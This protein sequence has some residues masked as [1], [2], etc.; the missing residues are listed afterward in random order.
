M[1]L[2][3]VGDIA[4]GDHPKAVGFGFYS[5]YKDGIPG[6][7][8][9]QLYPHGIRADLIFGNLEF[10]LADEE[11][12]GHSIHEVYCRGMKRYVTFLRE[13]GFSVLNMA[14]NHQ[15][16]H[17]KKHFADTIDNLKSGGIRVCGTPD[18]FSAENILKVAGQSVAFLGWSE[19]PRQDF[20]ETSLYNEFDEETAYLDIE[21][22]S[23]MVDLLCVSIHWGEE[24]VGIM[25]ERE[26]TIA[27]NMID[28]GSSI[29]IGHHPHVIREVESYH[30]GIIA[31][32]LG[33]FICDM[34]WNNKTKESG[35]LCVEIEGDKVLGHSFH[36]AIIGNDYFPHYLPSE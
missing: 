22:M 4:L 2:L 1:K 6:Q 14:N 19:R 28:H 31:Y 23:K 35:F 3:F 7:M 36:P 9:E 26:R 27:R 13:A 12:H 15:Y 10:G 8:A 33:N 29:V 32:S 11:I 34:I 30:G 17:G 5:K 25:N 16:Q 20:S 21:R 24:F 18:D